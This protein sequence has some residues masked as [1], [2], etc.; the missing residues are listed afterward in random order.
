MAS[1]SARRLGGRARS[2]VI[3]VSVL[4]AACSGPASQSAHEPEPVTE[5]EAT[6]A[7]ERLRVIASAQTTEAMEELCALTHEDCHGFSAAVIAEPASAP[8]AD[9]A[10]PT[11]LCD[12][13]A[14][15]GARMLVVEG[16]DGRGVAYVSQMVFTRNDRGQVVPLREPAFWLGIVYRS[17]S[18]VGAAT[19]TSARHP[20]PGATD[21]AMASD[22]LEQARSSCVSDP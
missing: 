7:L 16:V 13:D 22:L 4:V 11:V 3:C 1:A 20:S 9:V 15:E 18:V 17:S 6:R 19:W 21:E 12:R 14:G 10:A 2:V 5:L 8:G